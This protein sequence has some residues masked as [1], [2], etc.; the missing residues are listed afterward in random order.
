MEPTKPISKIE[1][2]RRRAGL[3]QLELSQK[4]GVTENTIANWEKGRSGLDWIEKLIR[5]CRTLDCS[6]EDLVE[7]PPTAQSLDDDTS[8]KHLRKLYKAGKEAR[9]STVES[10]S[11]R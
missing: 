4:V 1:D 5:L 7:Y 10:N 6:L 8:F 2:L 3:T 9:G 11:E